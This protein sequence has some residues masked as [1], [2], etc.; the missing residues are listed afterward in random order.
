MSDPMEGYVFN[1]EQEK[2]QA[3][4]WFRRHAHEI[5][6]MN[7]GLKINGDP[8]IYLG[9]PEEWQLRALEPDKFEGELEEGEEHRNTL[10]DQLLRKA[11]I[12]A[13]LTPLQAWVL[14]LRAIGVK[15]ERIASTLKIT[16]QAAIRATKSAILKINVRAS[17][18]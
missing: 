8:I 5:P 18:A 15:Q 2:A 10:V 4:E 11:V 17:E 1:S 14:A 13:D 6:D 3:E 16:R 7:A 9:I 12:E